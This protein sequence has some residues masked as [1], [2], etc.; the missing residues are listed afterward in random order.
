MRVD[1]F[2]DV[3]ALHTRFRPVHGIVLLDKP[4]GISSNQALQTVRRL[5]RA[6]KGGHTGA[7]DPLATGLLPLCFGEATKLAHHLLDARKGYLARFQL[8]VTTTT[9]DCEGEVIS[10]RP[11]TVL[12]DVMLEQALAQFRGPIM[13]KPPLYS[14]LKRGGEALYLKA[15]RGEK[16]DVKPREVIIHQL[17]CR[18]RSSDT[19]TLYVECS[20]GT[21]IRA[22]ASDLGDML[23]CGAHLAYLR[24]LWLSPFEQPVMFTL[25]QLQDLAAK[26]SGAMASCC[27]LPLDIALAGMPMYHLNASQ[28]LAVAQGKRVVP[29]TPPI[30]GPC[31]LYA[32]NG[33][34]LALAECDTEG[35]IRIVRGFN[36]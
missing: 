14:A 28:S 17:R 15:R 8:G 16:I 7:L 22:L 4:S 21:Y 6:A 35:R 25:E 30:P 23:G 20:S 10:R 12:T 27:L 34:L 33:R 5:L 13:Q 18:E 3:P 29:A 9:A 31:A 11:V 19:L 26:G 1:E 36:L 32:D 24:R 2:K